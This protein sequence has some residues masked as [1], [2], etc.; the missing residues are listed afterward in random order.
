MSIMFNNQQSLDQMSINQIQQ[1]VH[2]AS[3]L[4]KSLSHPTRLM[5]LYHLTQGEL[6]V[7]ELE[8]K[9]GV[10]QP[11]LSQQLG[12]LRRDE[13]VKTRREGKK[14]FYSVSNEDALAV[15]DTLYVRFC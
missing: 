10:H 9:V 3:Q 1:S 14:I 2:H 5:L 13:L 4:L 6:C 11:S 7:N 8:E 15:L 12:I